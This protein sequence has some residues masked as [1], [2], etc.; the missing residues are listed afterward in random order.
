[1]VN[2][3]KTGTFNARGVVVL[4]IHKGNAEIGKKKIIN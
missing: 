4:S 2:N 1:M 3:I